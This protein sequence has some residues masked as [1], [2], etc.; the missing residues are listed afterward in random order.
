MDFITHN[1]GFQIN[2]N[3]THLQ[4]YI[5]A[6]YSHL[7]DLLGES[8]SWDG[9]KTD[10][11]WNIEFEDGTVATVYNWKNGPNY[12]AHEV[13]PDMI[14]EWHVGGRSSKALENVKKI[15]LTA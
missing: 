15:L 5:N 2:T 12:G 3:F 7:C 4:G 8:Q 1:D 14:K 13:T 6:S 10:W 9:Y 11:E